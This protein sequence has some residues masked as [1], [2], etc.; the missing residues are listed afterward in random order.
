MLTTYT[1]H[2]PLPHMGPVLV[3]P[4]FQPRGRSTGQRSQ[5]TCL[6]YIYRLITPIKPVYSEPLFVTVPVVIGTCMVL[7]GTEESV[8]VP[9]QEHNS[10]DITVS[11]LQ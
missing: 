10:I 6:A 7:V 4:A 9:P 3:R 5:L 11:E 1:S 8:P 2:L